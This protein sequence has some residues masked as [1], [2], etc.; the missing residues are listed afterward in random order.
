MPLLIVISIVVASL[1]VVAIAVAALRTMTLAEKSTREVT[2]LSAEIH[3]WIG[4]A[5]EFTR[6]ARETLASARGVIAPIRRVADR[7]EMLGERTADLS[8]AIL[9]EIEPPVRTAVAVARGMRSMTTYF[10][11]RLSN[12]FTHGRAATNGGSEHEQE[13]ADL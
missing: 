12:R 8:S 6:E 4:Q 3:Q 1:A 13:S 10:L 5:N 11:E 9:G 2:K 7:F